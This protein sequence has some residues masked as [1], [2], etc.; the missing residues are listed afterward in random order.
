MSLSAKLRR[1][2]LRAV[3]GAFILNS[4]V[5]KLGADDETAKN[6]HGMASGTYGFLGNLQP[7]T[8]TKALGVGE[9]AVGS[10]L[11]L[12]IVP[13][14]VAGLSGA[15]VNLYWRTPGLHEEGNP[16]PTSA[17]IPMAKDVWMLG[18]GTGL[19]ADA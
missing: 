7:G 15:L 11:L 9:V 3:T 17:G 2:P 1:A 19:V 12:P 16:R 14:A 18:I 5:G 10:A 6:L 8:F 4:G 13:P